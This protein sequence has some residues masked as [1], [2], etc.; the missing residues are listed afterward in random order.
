MRLA[1]RFAAKGVMKPPPWSW[2]YH[3]QTLNRRALC[4]YLMRRCFMVLASEDFH[5]IRAR[6]CVVTARV[7][8]FRLMSGFT[9]SLEKRLQLMKARHG[10]LEK[11]LAAM[12]EGGSGNRMQPQK[13]A[14]LNKELSDLSEVVELMAHLNKQ[15][16]DLAFLEIT[17]NDP[18]PEMAA[19]AKEEV[20][21]AREG[22][23]SLEGAI[24]RLL[25]PR[26]DGDDRNLIL[27]V[28]AGTGG[29]EAGL[30]TAEVFTMYERYAALNRW[31]FDILTYQKGDIGGLREATASVSGSEAYQKLKYES[32]VHRVQR[33]PVNDVR[34]HT[35]AM[36]VAVLPEPQD[37][38]LRID[39]KDLKIDVYRASGA[40]GQ[41]VNTTES[42]VRVTHI[43]TGVVVAIQDERSQHKNKDKALKILRARVYEKER[44]RIMAQQAS[45]R[46]LQVGSGDRSERIRTYNFAQDRITDHRVSL[47]KHGMERM[48]NGELL[49]DFS[50][51]LRGKEE[52]EKL[53]QLLEGTG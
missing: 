38:D 47:S 23:S 4:R 28:R 17:L 8:S 18:D 42:A 26:D 41:H 5:P 12:H 31:R 50:A 52:T 33:V 29:D 20:E 22:V 51:A 7:G 6:A 45:D 36:T 14:S 3:G 53:Q 30:F 19:M 10:E 9:P 48:L 25:L 1:A 43:P 34:I 11:E 40:G 49:E 27:E 44:E 37:V 2:S 32:G 13:L 16:S 35:S 21:R 15:R 24:L 39:N 46:K